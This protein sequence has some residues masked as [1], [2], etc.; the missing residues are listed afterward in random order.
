[1]SVP[2]IPDL[3]D[4][5][6]NRLALRD[7]RSRLL[8]NR[9]VFRAFEQYALAAGDPATAAGHAELAA[10]VAMHRHPGLLVSSRLEQQ[11]SA[12]GRELVRT[13]RK[14]TDARG[15]GVQKVLH[16]MT[17]AYDSGGHTRVVERWITADTERV[18]TVALTGWHGGP[19]PKTLHDAAHAAGGTVLNIPGDDALTRA[20][21]L[22]GL[23][24]HHDLVVLHIH[25]FDVISAV[26]L[27]DPNGRPP[28]VLFNH[29]G[30]EFW[31]GAGVADVV[32][33]LHDIDVLHTHQRRGVA[34]EASVLLP[35]PVTPR[36]LPSRAEARAKLN[37]DT[38]S[39]V[40]LTVGSAYKV[41]NA[42]EPT[43]TTLVRTVMR[44]VPGAIM[45]AVGPVPDGEWAEL[46]TE[47]GGRVMPLGLQ[48][49]PMLDLLLPAADIL[50]DT[51][52]LT[53][54]TTLLDA[55]YARLPVVSLG[56]GSSELA[57]VRPGA[58]ALGGTV[59]H[60]SSPAELAAAIE[61]LLDDPPRRQE[62][63]ERARTHVEQ[64]HIG[65][66]GSQLNSVVEL[67]VARAGSA[68][69]PSADPPGHASDWECIV[70]MIK[71]TG[72]Q[73]TP[74][75]ELMVRHS[76]ALPVA[77]RR[78]TLEAYA[79]DVDTIVRES[80][81]S[82]RRAVVK[83]ALTDQA[84]RRLTERV[85]ELVESDRIDICVAVVDPD[86]LQEAVP[87][88]EQ[89]M[90]S[91]PDIDIELVAATSVSSV[92]RLDDLLLEP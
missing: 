22:R 76:P 91:L 50:L 3:L 32:A 7:A 74:P 37:L 18:P 13:P 11:L 61:A 40:I 80:S 46:Q 26:A 51:W 58:D 79:A 67:A 70:A 1:M 60:A 21:N 25:E 34:R 5:E 49:S 24:Q 63:G 72:G 6:A 38:G 78:P 92:A 28:T 68:L 29:A 65:G 87:L 84:V 16:V 23:A 54:W 53:G 27:A 41:A 90:A 71:E 8:A 75:A 30:H 17:E 9:R 2:R 10:S 56:D 73:A 42:V 89:A 20:R 88:F 31:V 82:A 4:G 64:N 57:M 14:L 77:E 47:F 66:W 86:S 52:P 35:I 45:V 12:I 15:A 48:P 33:N 44:A 69:P 83:P 19:P 39:H 59:T 81:P 36:N 43:F 62:I 85:W 55:G